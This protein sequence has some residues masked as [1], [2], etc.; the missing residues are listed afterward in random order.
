MPVQERAGEWI[1]RRFPPI[2]HPASNWASLAVYVWAML[3]AN[4]TLYKTGMMQTVIRNHGR[5][6]PMFWEENSDGG[7][8]ERFKSVYYRPFSFPAEARRWKQYLSEK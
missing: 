7:E 4:T 6:K 1:A 3:M 5:D 8:S 2:Q